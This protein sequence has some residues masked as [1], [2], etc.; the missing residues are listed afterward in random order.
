MT[1]SSPSAPHC[2]AEGSAPAAK[3]C[4]AIPGG[5]AE[6]PWSSTARRRSSVSSTSEP[7]MV[8]TTAAFSWSRVERRAPSA[9]VGRTGCSS[10]TNNPSIRSVRLGRMTMVCRSVVLS[11]WSRA[12]ASTPSEIDSTAAN[13]AVPMT[14]PKVERKVRRGLARRVANPM[15]T[16]A[17]VAAL[18]RGEESVM[19]GLVRSARVR[20][21]T[22][23][24][25]PRDPAHPPWWLC[26]TERLTHGGRSRA[27]AQS[28]ARSRPASAPVPQ[29][30][31]VSTVAGG[32][33]DRCR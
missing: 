26:T 23:A 29:L 1:T 17:R 22:P 14:M 33:T 12:N 9:T 32:L 24:G 4:S 31:T 11:I 28:A 27:P 10:G 13:A 8:S 15:E 20:G 16:E 7:S 19:G 3:G 30:L 18:V 25:R 2:A 21:F 5:G 6:N